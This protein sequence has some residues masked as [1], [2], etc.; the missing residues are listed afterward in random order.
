MKHFFPVLFLAVLV[1]VVVA[2]SIAVVNTENA[3]RER[4]VRDGFEAG[5][6]GI[7][8]EAC[9]YG[10]DGWNSDSRSA[11]WWRT[12]WIEEKK[13]AGEATR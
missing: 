11:R 8:V 13:S 10:L 4:V 2:I 6:A 3:S 9:P 7:P 5:R 12:G 1:F